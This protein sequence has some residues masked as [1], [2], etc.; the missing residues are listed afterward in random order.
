[1]VS[2][3]ALAR[4]M[5]WLGDSVHSIVEGDEDEL[6]TYSKWNEIDVQMYGA[7]NNNIYQQFIEYSTP[8]KVRPLKYSSNSQTGTS[9]I[10]S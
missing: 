3:S 1:M 6:S 5:T 2:S 4:A 8:Y 9:S 7:E 10:Q